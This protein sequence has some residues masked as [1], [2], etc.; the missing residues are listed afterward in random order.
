M[1]ELECD[2]SSRE[3]SKALTRPAASVSRRL[4]ADSQRRGTERESRLSASRRTCVA[5]MQAADLRN[6]HD[7]TL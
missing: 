2:V 5:M 1:G 4:S 3:I 6:G 7:L